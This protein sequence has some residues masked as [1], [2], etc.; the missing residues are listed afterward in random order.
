MG[1]LVMELPEGVTLTPGAARALAG[2]AL[3][4][5][6]VWWGAVE[7]EAYAGGAGTLLFLRPT[8]YELRLLPFLHK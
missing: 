8:D 5:R 2:L 3:R 4:R 6:G 7:L 1:F